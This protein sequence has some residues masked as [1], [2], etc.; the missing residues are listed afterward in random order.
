MSVFKDM[1]YLILLALVA[2]T[3]CTDAPDTMKDVAQKGASESAIAAEES[4]TPITG[5]HL[6]YC[7]KR[8]GQIKAEPRRGEVC[9]VHG[10]GAGGG[11]LGPDKPIRNSATLHIASPSLKAAG[12]KSFSFNLN[13]GDAA[14][15][16]STG[17]HVMD[18]VQLAG[19]VPSPS[20]QLPD[21]MAFVSDV[22]G[23]ET[24]FSWSSP[25]AAY[26]KAK[27]P[28]FDFQGFEIVT[29]T[30]IVDRAV[31]LPMDKFKTDFA[32]QAGMTIGEQY[33]EGTLIITLNPMGSK[34]E[35][36]GPTTFEFGTPIDWGYSK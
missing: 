1:K 15:K 18:Q 2:L 14:P 23:K 22:T 20:S 25:D 21:R 35:M 10:G 9:K 34:G 26:L 27:A 12:V 4:K 28:A 36:Y 30:L 19:K 5:Q 7:F 17:V 31:D 3:A 13:R 8:V 24:L 33:I 11:D 6:S 32:R 16:F 29:A